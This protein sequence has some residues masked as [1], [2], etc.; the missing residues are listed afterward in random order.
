MTPL[1]SIR[2]FCVWCVKGNNAAIRECPSEQ[3]ALVKY[4]MGKGR[5]STLRAIRA[6]C[7][8][9]SALQP[10]KVHDCTESDCVLYQYR[11]GHSPARKGQGPKCPSFVKKARLQADSTCPARNRGS[12]TFG[13]SR[14]PKQGV[15]I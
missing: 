1:R 13:N 12:D 3:C 14:P 9:C 8:D 7:L 4:R 11:M 15:L 10:S 2:A 6:K 5:G